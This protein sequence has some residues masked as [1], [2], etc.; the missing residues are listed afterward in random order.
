MSGLSLGEGD[1]SHF[2]DVILCGFLGDFLIFRG[3]LVVTSW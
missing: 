2:F 3:V 1:F